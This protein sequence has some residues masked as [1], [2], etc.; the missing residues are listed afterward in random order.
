MNHHYQTIDSFFDTFDL[1]AAGR[2]LHTAIKTADS[3]KI[4]NDIPAEAL[5]FIERLTELTEAVFEL[6]HQYDYKEEVQIPK[7]NTATIFTL[8]HYETYCGWH[9]QRTAWDFFPRHLSKKEFRN[10]YKALEKFTRYKTLPQW[11]HILK[12]ICMYALSPESISD[13]N[14]GESLVSTAHQLHKMLEA[15]HLIEV[16]QVTSSPKP[17]RKW[18]PPVQPSS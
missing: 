10:P 15:A 12:E 17:R 7:E 4:W 18:K 5:C 6:I 16:R 3:K 8:T 2:L 9:T 1:A 11:K 13:L 14:E